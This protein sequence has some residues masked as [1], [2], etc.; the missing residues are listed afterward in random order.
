M[1]RF[2]HRIAIKIRGAIIC[3]LS[4]QLIIVDLKF[5]RE[6]FG[7]KAVLLAEKAR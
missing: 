4:A 2:D 3:L 6:A 7:V 1:D 5:Y